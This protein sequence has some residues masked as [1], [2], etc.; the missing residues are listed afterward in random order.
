MRRARVRIHT[1]LWLAAAA[2]AALPTGAVAATP[3]NIGNGIRPSVAVDGAGNGYFVW[4]EQR[5]SNQVDPAQV[6]FCKVLAGTSTCAVS[7]QFTVPAGPSYLGDPSGNPQV[8]LGPD[9]QPTIITGCS[10]CFGG[11]S[12]T[13]QFVSSNGGTSFQPR[14][15]YGTLGLIGGAYVTGRGEYDAA[16]DA[17]FGIDDYGEFQRMPPTTVMTNPVALS[18]FSGGSLNEAA[19]SF[20]GSGATQTH[21]A[22]FG[23]SGIGAEL[24]FKHHSNPSDVNTPGN[25][26]GGDSSIGTTSHHV[27][28]A[29]GPSGIVLVSGRDNPTLIEAR[30]FALAGKTFGAATTITSGAQGDGSIDSVDVYQA[31]NGRL[32]AL[33]HVPS[34]GSVPAGA[35]YATSADGVTWS[36]PQSI[37]ADAKMFH[38]AVAGTADANKGWIVYG[39]DD[40]HDNAIRVATLDPLPAVVPPP[41]PPPPLPPPPPPPPAISPTYTGAAKAIAVS[42]RNAS[43]SFSVPRGCVAPGQSFTATLKWKRKKRKGSVFVK[44]SRV[45]FYLESKRLAIDRTPPFSYRYTIVATQ[46]RGSTIELRAR[47]FTKVRRGKAPKKSLRATITVC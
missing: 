1:V 18:P 5:G 17:Y 3:F 28:L 39:N 38:A 47:A 40:L 9:G 12:R 6:H 44:V 4:L 41:P 27:S 26:V 31:P 46:R 7:S 8:F 11:G 15:G 23:G 37:V 32:H 42:D 13:S 24:R 21:V 16:A 14:P 30:V 35:R 34:G 29:T 20:A 10:G 22:A 2:A 36:A 33:W 43:Y 19:V 45:D 25:W